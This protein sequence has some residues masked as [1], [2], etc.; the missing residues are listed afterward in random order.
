MLPVFNLTLWP[1]R[2]GR[3]RRRFADFS[4]A[5]AGAG[6]G[7]KA[8]QRLFPC[9]WDWA[10]SAAL[11]PESGG[12]YGAH[13]AAPR[14]GGEYLLL[15]RQ[16]APV[17]H[18]LGR[19]SHGAIPMSLSNLIRSVGRSKEAS[20]GIILGGILNIALDPLFM[21]VLLPK[22]TGGLGARALPR[23]FPTAWRSYSSWWC[24]RGWEKARSSP[25]AH[26]SADRS[27]RALRRSLA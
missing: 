3:C 19:R 13:F 15:C 7:G 6:G 5:G 4:P 18:C 21:F 26:G 24:W 16:Y 25:S 23:A 8:R 27:G 17:G 20:I 14:R 11:F 1:G 12:V 2:L 9:C 10:I 22:G